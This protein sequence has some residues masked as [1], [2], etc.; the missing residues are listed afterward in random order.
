M[1][2]GE[3][4]LEGERYAKAPECGFGFS[5]LQLRD[6]AVMPCPWIL[7]RMLQNVSIK[8]NSV[9]QPSAFVKGQRFNELGCKVLRHVNSGRG[10]SGAVPQDW[11][12]LIPLLYSG[13]VYSIRIQL[14]HRRRPNSMVMLI[15]RFS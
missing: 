2:Y 9:C 6:S 1:E 10:F 7:G 3:R 5:S 8:T 13:V 14:S 11:S 15:R 4:G 12:Y